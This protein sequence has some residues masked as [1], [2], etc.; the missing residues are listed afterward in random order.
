MRIELLLASVLAAAVP[1]APAAK[2]Q[3]NLPWCGVL[4]GGAREC[5][6]HT[7]AQCEAVMRP[8]GGDCQPRE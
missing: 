4:D 7:L 1:F 2:A 6:Y 5:V 8:N 3:T